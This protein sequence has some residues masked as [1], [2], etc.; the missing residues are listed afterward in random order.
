VSKFDYDKPRTFLDY[1]VV[2]HIV[3][4]TYD[5][6]PFQ[7]KNEPTKPI[8]PAEPAQVYLSINMTYGT[9]WDIQLKESR[10]EEPE[11]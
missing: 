6:R 7:E 9:E 11:S 2:G 8:T 1:D 10:A 5:S 4:M 3:N